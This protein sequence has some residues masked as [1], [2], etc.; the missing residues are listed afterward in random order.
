MTERRFCPTCGSALPGEAPGPVCPHCLP[1]AAVPGPD[2]RERLPTESEPPESPYEWLALIGVLAGG[3]AVAFGI[4]VARTGWVAI[5]LLAVE[6][7]AHAITWRVTRR[8]LVG[9]ALALAG[10]TSSV[11]LLAVDRSLWWV[12]FLIWFWY[13]E[14]VFRYFQPA[15]AR[16]TDDE[17]AVVE[18]LTDNEKKIVAALK[19]FEGKE[20]LAVIP[21]LDADQ[22]QDLREAC[23]VPPEERVLALWTLNVSSHT[24]FSLLVASGGVYLFRDRGDEKEL[25]YLAFSE[26]ASRTFVNHGRSVYLGH[27]Q[28][29]APA[30]EEGFEQ[31]EM[32]CNVLNAVQKVV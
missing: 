16:V 20:G 28:S 22:Q 8:V 5:G 12:L 31:C 17:D 10:I 32:L 24:A 2:E 7:L 14:K 15:G 18:G 3:L 6:R 9:Q 11:T 25:V 27:G 4:L 19:R 13:G 30:A 23:R 1:R 26:Y 29:F 21:N